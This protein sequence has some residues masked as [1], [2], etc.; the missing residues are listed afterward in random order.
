MKPPC[1][2]SPSGISAASPSS[3]ITSVQCFC[4]DPHPTP[5]IHAAIMPTSETPVT[6]LLLA[7]SLTPIRLPRAAQTRKDIAK[8][9][10]L[11]LLHSQQLI[12]LH[13]CFLLVLWISIS[14]PSRKPQS[15]DRT[16]QGPLCCRALRCLL[17][18]RLQECID[19]KLSVLYVRGRRLM[20]RQG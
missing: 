7:V 2:I 6:A 12:L 19:A 4:S 10:P 17:D 9:S 20:R 1:Q 8:D 11:I 16:V 5:M 3:G 13:L 18:R 14:L 15:K